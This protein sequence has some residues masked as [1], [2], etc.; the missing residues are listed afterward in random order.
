MLIQLGVIVLLALINGFFALS[1]MAIVASRKS[2]LKHMAQRSARA[3][4]AVAL[5]SAPERFLST[6][7]VGIT[8]LMLGT[9]AVTGGSI[10]ER[11]AGALEQLDLSWLALHATTIGWVVGFIV[12]TSIQIVIGELVPKRIALVAPERLATQIAVPMLVLSKIVAPFVWILNLAGTGILKVL[13]LDK[14]HR[15]A[16]TEEEIRLL[17]AEGAEQGVL[18]ADERNMVSRVLRLGDRDVD[19]VMTPRTRIVWLDAAASR[20]HNLEILEN[21]PYSRYPVYRNDEGDVIGVI[22]IKR[23]LGAIVRGDRDL[24]QHLTKPLFVPE[25]VRA[26][27]L[28]EE[29]RESDSPIALVV[30]E[31]GDIMGMVTIN[32]LL[33]SVVGKS[34]GEMARN[35]NQGP[36]SPI[37]RRADGSWLVDG[38]VS[39]DDLRELLGLDHL[40]NEDEHEFHTVGGMM[41]TAFGRIPGESETFEWRGVRFEIVDLDGARIDKVLVTPPDDAN[42][43]EIQRAPD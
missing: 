10:G 18:D 30:N 37:V 35:E 38:G 39:T 43:D 32:D 41:M 34:V 17:V 4:V 6:V 25:T 21:T 24:F 3:R 23:L 1:E 9:G 42:D 11:L 13:H 33:A 15:E 7:Q 28:L 27:D 2:R 8:A 36:Q 19:S 22:E 5:A 16:V 20:Q 14:A 31:Y 12:A 26:L 40:P 29:F